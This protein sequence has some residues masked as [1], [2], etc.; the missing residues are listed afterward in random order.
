MNL[1]VAELLKQRLDE[2]LREMPVD[3]SSQVPLDVQQAVYLTR[4]LQRRA[5]ELQTRQERRQ[6][7]EFD[8]MM[9]HPEEKA[10][11]MK[12]TDQAFR[13]RSPERVADQLTHV[14]DVQGIPRF[15]SPLERA[16]LK[17]FQSFGGYLP[18]VS[19]PAVKKYMQHETANVILPA[20]RELL[21]DH[22]KQRTSQ[23]IRMNVNIL[24]E[25]LLGEAEAERRL[26]RYLEA[27]QRPEIEV[28]SVKISTIFSQISSL[29]LQHSVD[30]LVRRL[31]LL[32]RAASK[33]R[34][35]HADGSE[36]SKFVYLDMEEYRDLAITA[37]AFM[38]VLDRPGMEQVAAGIALQSYIP[39]S[40][41]VQRTLNQ[42]ARQRVARGGQPIVIRLV[43]GANLETERV[44]ASLSGWP[45]APYKSKLETD[46]NFKRMLL[47]GL[48]RE[49]IE[50]AHLGIASHNLF[51]VAFALVKALE[52][53]VL[54]HLQ[55]EMLEGMANHQRRSL[56][57]FCSNLLLYAPA[58]T[59]DDFI[60][61]IGYLVRRLDENTGEDNFLRHT[62]KLEVGG[63]EW[64]RL[65]E[66]FVQSHQQISDVSDAPRRKQDRNSPP[67]PTMAAEH[68]WQ[69]FKN[70]PDTDF[71]L[72]KNAQWAA[73][74]V[75]RWHKRTAE[76]PLEI[77][78]VIGGNEVSEDRPS[79]DSLDPSRPGHVVGRY[80]QATSD[81]IQ[82]AV[83]CARD[84]PDGWRT[85]PA[86][87]RH[88]IM[89]QAAQQLR[90]ARGD[91][92]GIAL[93][94]GGKTLLESDPE[95]SEAVDFVE[96]YSRTADDFRSL[97]GV[98]TA[99]RG[100]VVV[101]SPWNFPIAIPCGGVAAALAAG[102]TVI[103]KPASDTVLTAHMMCEC[104]WKAGVSR[105]ALQ[106]V[107]CSGA[108]AGQHL[109]S[110]PAVDVVILTGGTDTAIRMLQAKPDLNL[111]AETGG[112]NATI[113]TT[114]SDR[115]LAIKHV[116][117]SAFSHS[118]QKCSATSLLILE[119]E[120]F[121][122]E[123][124][125]KAL[126]DAVQSIPL[127]PA[128][129]LK[130]KMGPLIRP[131]SGDLEKGL[132][133]LEE[134]EAWAVMPHFDEQNE[135][136][137]SPGIKWGTRPGSYTHMTE[138]FGPVLAVMKAKN[139]DE[140][141]RYVNQTGYGLTSGIESLDDRELQT[142]IESIQAGNLYVNRSTTGAIVLR[143]PFGG[144]GKSAFGPGI[145]AGGPN[146]VM[147]LMQFRDQE[148]PQTKNA[149]VDAELVVLC[150]RMARFNNAK[151]EEILPQLMAA[152]H[153]YQ[154]A[155]KN[156]FGQSHDHFQLVGQDNFR[157][158]LPVKELRVR[159][160]AEDSVFEIVARVLAA[161][162]AGCRTTVSKPPELELPVFEELESATRAWAGDIEFV[163]ETDDQLAEVIKSQHTERIRYATAARVPISIRRAVI[164]TSI[165]VA[166]APIL[167]QG[168]IELLWYLRE[169]SV[170]VDYHRYGNLGTRSQEP[171]AEPL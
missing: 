45:Q 36:S 31:E 141:I 48:R 75:Q 121:H 50:A 44:D 38:K 55:F 132:K 161:R 108:T 117:H 147:Q 164:D 137:V 128:W 5:T 9:Q 168:R 6:Q 43:K 136:L 127:G 63:P 73:D 47:E 149:D 134:G 33:N 35:R 148:P 90:E 106:L 89:R 40:Y 17:G 68:T 94:E 56:F 28:I 37:E 25:A 113:V 131:A 62:F 139:L 74:L 101:V 65:E 162:I 13:A 143:Q 122:D 81:D 14:L 57:E 11:L 118:G 95:V 129:D 151:P 46:A 69:E 107:P 60:H 10:T 88:S 12:I 114:L 66:M 39:D 80:R 155:M 58:C 112:K 3:D 116:I 130:T 120:V 7:A 125:R 83:D 72:P 85:L 52:N 166:D 163:E 105:R 146:Y 53:G 30:V 67:T 96:F 102:N 29:A 150:E 84:D 70:E 159:V 26:S 169:Q 76:R 15:F 167:M 154:Q 23:G 16:A 22:L 77:P 111:L 87:E 144:M 171:R 142:W 115:D 4:V 160:H 152:A 157:R 138:F 8:R 135:Q 104:F 78:L 97:D 158:Y 91:L 153:S 133:E 123:E 93:A 1:R 82:Q 61:A 98:E 119:E 18:G 64:Q 92:M 21:A 34:F 20:E 103:L 24:G 110:H 100:V 165:Y 51:E 41:Q 140:A 59:R 27:L 109:V 99:P 145:K 2:V 79:V 42:W 19:V 170:C 86:N 32:Y 126:C 156:E 124:F 54:E 49:N 71:S